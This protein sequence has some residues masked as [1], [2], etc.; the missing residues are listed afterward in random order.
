[1]V[2]IEIIVMGRVNLN[3][4]INFDNLETEF[5]WVNEMEKL[6]EELIFGIYS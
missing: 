5:K 2:N 4:E 6:K 1:M 3:V